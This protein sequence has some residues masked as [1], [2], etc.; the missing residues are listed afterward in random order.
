MFDHSHTKRKNSLKGSLD[1]V[2][3]GAEIEFPKILVSRLPQN[4]SN[5]NTE[6]ARKSKQLHSFCDNLLGTL[7]PLFYYSDINAFPNDYA[8]WEL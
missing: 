8:Q 7:M 5:V 3:S 1:L 4:T 2:S 6:F